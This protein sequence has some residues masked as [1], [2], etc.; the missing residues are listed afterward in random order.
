MG[1]RPPDVP[2]SFGGA[3]DFLLGGASVSVNCTSETLMM[4]M[5][6]LIHVFTGTESG[7]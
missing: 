6:W 3:D 2:A 7:M 5:K 4:K 1:G